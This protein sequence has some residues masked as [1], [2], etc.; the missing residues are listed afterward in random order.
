MMVLRELRNLSLSGAMSLMVLQPSSAERLVL[1]QKLNV[2]GD[3]YANLPVAM[4]LASVE[5]DCVTDSASLYQGRLAGPPADIVDI[6]EFRVVSAAGTGSAQA[7]T[8]PLIATLFPSAAPAGT[9]SVRASELATLWR[10]V[11][12]F[13]NL[14]ADWFGRETTVPS[15]TLAQEVRRILDGLPQHIRVPQ[16]TASGDGEIALTWFSGQDR[17]DTTVSPEGYLTWATKRGDNFLPGDVVDH[18][19]A[20][21]A[22]LYAALDTFYG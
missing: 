9:S 15:R 3:S 5:Q 17:F 8:R 12:R 4:R 13:T 18:D 19:A 11:E 16:A 22:T 20:G 6:A 1:D 7:S 10:R 21:R 14:P 2:A